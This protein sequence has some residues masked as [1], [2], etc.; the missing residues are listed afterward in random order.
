MMS[1]IITRDRSRPHS[2]RQGMGDT[3]TTIDWWPDKMY[4]VYTVLYVQITEL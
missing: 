1:S 4:A 3:W 2:D